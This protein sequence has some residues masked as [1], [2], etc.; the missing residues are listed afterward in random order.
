MISIFC[1]VLAPKLKLEQKIGLVSQGR[2]NQLIQK[3]DL[4]K[5]GESL[6]FSTYF[7]E[8]VIREYMEDAHDTTRKR[9]IYHIDN[10]L[11]V[12]RNR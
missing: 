12:K 9:F 4:L 5:V 10:G 7:E 11:N 2:R 1:H 3:L 6:A 8:L